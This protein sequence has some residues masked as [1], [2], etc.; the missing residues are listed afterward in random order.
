MARFVYEAKTGPKN[1]V[2]GT[3]VAETKPAAIQKISQMGYYLLSLETI[4]YY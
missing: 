4:Y 1:M 2:R 3:L